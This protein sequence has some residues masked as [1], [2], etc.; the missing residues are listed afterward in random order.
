MT[1]SPVDRLA[2]VLDQAGRALDTVRD[3][4][5]D[6]P[7]PCSDWTVRQLA[8]HVATGPG[9]FVQMA[10]GE[11]V[12][13]SA[14][15]EVADGQWGATFRTGADELLATMRGLPDD[16]QGTV[17]FQVA[18]YAVHSWDLARGTGADLALDDSLAEAALAAMR[19]GL[20]D[21]NRQGA[22]GPEV[23]V[24]DDATAYERL[25]AFSGRDPRARP[26]SPPGSSGRDGCPTT[27]R[28]AG[29]P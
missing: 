23:P 26:P 20:T 4:N 14:T 19:G 6:H 17:A 1:S 22:F 27:V 10:R 9:R 5:L 8:A 16:Q 15:P 12:D 21:E 25:A 13:W 7:T 29:W 18:E 11:E 28:T 24:P 3:D 2:E